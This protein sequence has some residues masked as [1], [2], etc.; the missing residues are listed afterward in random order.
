MA[1]PDNAA[2]SP[3]IRSALWAVW[4]DA[5]GFP[6][7]L[8]GLRGDPPE[9]AD[10]QMKGPI[11]WRR[12]V[13]GRFG[14]TVELP[15]GSYSDDTQ[16]RLAVCR[17]IRASGR[18]DLEAFSKIELP[19]FLSYELGAGRGTRAAARGLERRSVRWR[20]NFFDERGVRYVEGGGN[21]A[22]MRIQPHVWAAPDFRPS[23]Y[24]LSCLNDA[25]TTHGHPRGILG[26]GLHALSLGTALR[27]GQAPDPSRWGDMA[28]YLDRVPSV[29][30]DDEQLADGW[31]PAWEQASGQK[32]QKAVHGVV[33]E[34][35]G[36]VA[37]AARMAERPNGVSPEET[38]ARLVRKLGGL[39]PATRGSGTVSAV[40]ALW[41]AWMSRAE[42]AAGLL[43][44]A[45]LRGSDTDTV[46]S[47][48]GA[49]LGATA[50]A[51]PPGAI[52]DSDLHRR[53]ADRLDR[54][55][56]GQRVDDFP[57]PDPLRWQPPRTLSDAL[58][59]TG[60]GPAVAGLGPASEQGRIE[61]G[62]GKEAVGW[63]WVRTRF[64]QTLIIKRRLK[65]EPL[66]EHAVGRRRTTARAEAAKQQELFDTAR[67]GRDRELPA[68]VEEGVA[69]LAS[70]RFESSLLAR[71]LTHYARQPEGAEKAAAF[72]RLVA[73][74]LREREA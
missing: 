33:E 14:P 42:P 46:A 13:G 39:E 48:A 21:G 16:L 62:Q 11:A 4:G 6:M 66:A 34:L 18:F 38:Y 2:S 7:E 9:I 44:A 61:R 26:A 29:M 31:L 74:A 15:A 19:V 22:A 23:S 54:L 36:Q 27:E 12:R 69:L 30:E 73:E 28:R 24:L 49:L 40:L 71:L 72:G 17:C 64:G 10:G 57:H 45:N 32:W 41:L 58:G 60:D 47:M 59:T 53:E 70:R 35:E 37:E 65:L 3:V 50:T 67:A 52:L 20:S 25:V 56:E 68:A 51:E 55:R 8:R 1:C 63:Q 43:V 5:V